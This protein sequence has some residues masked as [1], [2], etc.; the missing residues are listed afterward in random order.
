MHNPEYVLENETHK[1]LSDF[2]IKTDH[3]T[4]TRR[5]EKM[6]IDKKHENPPKELVV[7]WILMFQWSTKLK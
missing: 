3:P 7:W 1:I 4:P 6:S 2:E 5:P